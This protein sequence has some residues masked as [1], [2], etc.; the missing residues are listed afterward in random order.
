MR[1]ADSPAPRRS[2]AVAIVAAIVLVTVA[3]AAGVFATFWWWSGQPRPVLPLEAHWSARVAVLAGTG[4]LGTRDGDALHARFSDPFG[5]AV[6]PDGTVFVADGANADRI[7][8]ISPAGDVTTVAGGAPGFVNGPGTVAQFNTPSGLAIDRGGTLY[9]ADTGNNAIR[10]ITPDGLVSTLA[11]DGTAGDQDGPAAT[12][13]FNGPIGIAVDERGRIVVADTYNDRI[14]TIDRD[15]TVR[16]LAG[17]TM[18]N[19]DGPGSDARFHTPSGV[20]VDSHGRVLVA[21]TGNGHVRTIDED[22]TVSTPSWSLAEPLLRPVGI[23]VGSTNDLYVTDERGRIVAVSSDGQA[24]TL[25][26]SSAGFHDGPGIDA[27]F[28]NPTAIA[29]ARPGHLVVADAGNALV[30]RIAAL[31]QPDAHLPP[32]PLVHPAFDAT[33]F[34]LTPLLW[35]VAPFEGPHEVAG[36]IGEARGT[37]G[38]GRFHAGV[39]VRIEEGTLVHAIRDG[40]VSSP[41]ASESFGTLN[42]WLRIGSLTY[43]HVRVGREGK[44]TLFGDPRFVSA[45][46]DDGKLS[47]VRAKRGAHFAAGEAIATVNPF[48]HV[49]LQVG[50]PGEELNPLRFDLVQFEDT[51]APTIPRGGIHLYDEA[52]QPITTRERGKLVVSGRVQVVVDAWDQ[53]NGNRPERRLGLYDLGYQVLTRDGAPAPGFAEVRHTI[54]FDRLP[55]GPGAAAILYAHGSGIPFY[56]RRRTQFLYIV[57]NRL[58]DGIP[59]T[60]MWDTTLLPPGEY[61]LRIWA[62]D[63]RGNVA[64]DNRDLS[65]IVITPEP[66][67]VS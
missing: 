6:A 4:V 24:R 17:S 56:G 9:V 32:P 47:A 43:I 8:R 51:V 65:L 29:V 54:R 19:L 2:K 16:T 12:A 42:E 35:P 36:T 67:P 64:I 63:I 5:V 10:R 14:R 60:D 48:N 40:V 18:G 11:G 7:R 49:H 1:A 58:K 31:S 33:T 62:A 57:T 38:N 41:I 30:R 23:A 37:E 28:R 15:G 26:G 59:S 44:R 21:D 50:W 34:G 61:R 45:Y 25:A 55:Q 13:R 53:S 46:G 27:R 66:P 52:G 39:D 22:G 20:A 3:V